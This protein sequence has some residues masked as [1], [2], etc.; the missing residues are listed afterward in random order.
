M[1]WD[2]ARATLK[3][4][5]VPSGYELVQ[6]RRADVLALVEDLRGWYPDI[7]VGAESCHLTP[8]FYY[9]QTMLADVAEDRPIL[10][11]VARHQ[12]AIVAMTT[13]EKNAS[14]RTIT[15]RMG[16]IAPAHRGPS[17]ALLG[18][19]LLERLGRAIGAEL[20]YY[21]ATLKSPHQQ[22]L[23]E[24]QRYRLVG[25]MPAHDR[26][27]VRPG[28]VKRVYEAIYAKVLVP[29]DAIEVPAASAL[30]VRTRAVWASLFGSLP[31]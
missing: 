20:A 3:E 6:L 26:D 31:A 7:V 19:M 27:M 23:A 15:C 14:A 13:F 9:E 21:F 2:G 4:T 10:P 1:N 22:V 18:P 11:I 29:D 16:A 24:R 8:E 5:K 30:T 12:G 17:L 28:E 25:I